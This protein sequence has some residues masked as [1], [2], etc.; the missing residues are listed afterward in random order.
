MLMFPFST[1]LGNFN[2]SGPQ[3]NYFD[4][5]LGLKVTFGTVPQNRKPRNAELWP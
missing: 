2:S 1:G 3:V 4:S 5:V